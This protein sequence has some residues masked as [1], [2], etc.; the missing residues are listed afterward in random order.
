MYATATK[1]AKEN[2]NTNM[3]DILERFENLSL[4][5]QLEIIR[6]DKISESLADLEFAKQKR[7][8]RDKENTPERHKENTIRSFMRKLNGKSK[9]SSIGMGQKS[10]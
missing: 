3:S 5:K 9:P 4:D 6:N 7:A 8:K 1:M 2:I 10:I